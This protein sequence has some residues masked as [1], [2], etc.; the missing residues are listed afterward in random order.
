MIELSI[1]Y[2]LNVIYTHKHK[3]IIHVVNNL[4]TTTRTVKATV[5]CY[6]IFDVCYL[7]TWI[8]LKDVLCVS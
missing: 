2:T 1:K 3:V 7:A 4:I 5:A 8:S 6:R